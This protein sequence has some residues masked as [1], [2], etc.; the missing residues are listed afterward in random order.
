MSELVAYS[1]L[2]AGESKFA[3]SSPILLLF[4]M[5]INHP[6]SSAAYV[7]AYTL[8]CYSL[9][10]FLM[11]TQNNVCSYYGF[12]IKCKMSVGKYIPSQSSV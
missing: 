7:V 11:K 4:K 12:I 1:C 10:K 5:I 6:L 9:F 8:C 2:D 3:V